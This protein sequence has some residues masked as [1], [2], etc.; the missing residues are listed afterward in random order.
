MSMV[1]WISLCLAL[2]S[3]PNLPRMQET[4]LR[5]MARILGFKSL[6]CGASRA[7]IHW[8]RDREPPVNAIIDDFL[9]ANPDTYPCLISYAHSAR[10][11]CVL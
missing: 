8:Q 11:G 2:A 4:A 3:D 9:D 1:G 6:A 7:R 10:C 5:V